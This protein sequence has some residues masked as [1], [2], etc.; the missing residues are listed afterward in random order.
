MSTDYI[1]LASTVKAIY[2]SLNQANLLD[3]VNVNENVH[4]RIL[5]MI[6][7]YKKNGRYPF[8]GSFLRIQKIADIL[9]K[10]FYV[11]RPCFFNELDR[12]DLLIEEERMNY[13]I[14]IENK[15]YDAVD[16][17]RQLERY[18]TS[19]M[20]RGINQERLFALYL[21][22]DGS[23][24]VSRDSMTDKAKEILGVAADSQGRF[25]EIDFK[26]DILP[27]LK[28]AI[29]SCVDNHDEQIK[30]ALNQY[31]DYLSGM[32]GQR[33]RDAV[34]EIVMTAILQENG[35]LNVSSYCEHIDAVNNL[36]SEL[37][38]RRDRI[39]D[40]LGK[41][42]ISLP[43]REYCNKRDIELLYESY[44]F[45]YLSISMS[46]PGLTKASFRFN[47]E[48]DG[49]NIYGICNRDVNDGEILP[50]QV[51]ARFSG[52]GNKVFRCSPWWPVW[53][54]PA[55]ERAMY[56]RTGSAFF[57]EVTVPGSLAKYIIESYEEIERILCEQQE[58]P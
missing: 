18:L 23:K 4:S 5:R 30:S 53:R 55:K 45:D 17:E 33:E 14:I 35:I 24:S 7:A 47:T 12:I 8:Y 52:F 28:D 37:V 32:F 48:G 38:G 22:A 36:S 25:S 6:L 43:L 39:C 2:D 15:V 46:L 31:V 58:S 20:S 51:V 34:H 16:Q 41:N 26:N 54:Y 57:W 44:S 9:P 10:D 27:W 21:T 42:Y 13:A 29:S 19:C 3:T 1:K 50:E 49:R 40:N 56:Y 11:G